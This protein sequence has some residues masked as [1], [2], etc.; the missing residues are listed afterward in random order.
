MTA[1][2]S[3]ARWIL[4]LTFSAVI[5][6]AAETRTQPILNEKFNNLYAWRP[7][8][9]DKIPRH[10]SYTIV[11]EK[12]D[13]V[14]KAKTRASAS[15]LIWRG[16]FDPAK[17]PILTWRWKVANILSKG[18]ATRKDGDDYPIRVYVVFKYDPKKASLS[19]R[20]KYALA[21]RLT[22]EYP[23]QSSLT[24]IWANRDHDQRILS[25][26]YT[27]RAKMVV[28]RKGKTD[29]GRWV[30]EKVNILKDYRAAFG[31]DPPSEASIAIMSDSDNT[32][33]SATAFLD[34]LRLSAE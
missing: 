17:D 5:L 6:L 11:K 29:V 34:D 14:L 22:G 28:L 4:T 1:N 16:A 30:K 20:L 12:G 25:S 31:Q 2:L 26:P 32:G 18:D 27:D 19:T 23:P 7:V 13:S 33:Q 3:S 9:F 8:T 15:G 24:Y 21:K 10:T